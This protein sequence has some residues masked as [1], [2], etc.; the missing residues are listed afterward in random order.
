M[1]AGAAPTEPQPARDA[2]AE[3]EA[4]GERWTVRVLGRSTS[5]PASARM[6]LLQLGFFGPGDPS[7]PRREALVVARDL[8]DMTEL[9]LLAAWQSAR[10]PRHP[11]EPRPFFPEIAG[12]GGKEG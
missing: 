9:E 4:D 3:M 6:P 11:G 12:K 2:Q 7:E 5:G 1:P 8:A 10:A